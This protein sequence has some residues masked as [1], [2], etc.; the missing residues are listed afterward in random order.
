[1]IP[2]D[3]TLRRCGRVSV[4]GS[5]IAALILAS[6][7]VS[8]INTPQ[9]TQV[10]YYPEC[11]EPVQSLRDLDKQYEHA[12]AINVAIGAALGGA[13]GAAA[14]GNVKGAIVGA[15]GGVLLAAA[16]TYAEYRLKQT[17]N[18]EKRRYAIAN[19]LAHDRGEMRRAVSAAR[20]ANSCYDARFRALKAGVH[21]R[22]ISLADAGQHF[23]EIQQGTHETEQILAEY[24]E[25][26][27]AS[28]EQYS[29]AFDQEAHR[30]NT[31]PQ[32]LEAKY[33]V[34]QHSAD[35][36]S[37]DSSQGTSAPPLEK[38]SS[39]KQLSQNYQAY[40]SEVGQI[41]QLNESMQRADDTRA[42]EMRGLGVPAS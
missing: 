28:S 14:S 36:S 37:D 33:R 30:L 39:A 12:L 40:N 26:A 2:H 7:S 18:D 41:A 10:H 13:V 6:C 16:G 11:Y 32:S 20:Q 5:S 22:S 15:L 8:G 25:K 17:P 24:G 38:G 35:A 4:V 23:T 19:D 31:T 27:K 29:A 1:M 9:T 34:R 21:N 42:N 3:S